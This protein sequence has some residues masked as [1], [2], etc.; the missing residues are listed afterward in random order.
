[1]KELVRNSFAAAQNALSDFLRDDSRLQTI[2]DIAG[3]IA[4][5]LQIGGKVLIFGNGGS[6]CDA[7]H[8]A[9]ELTGRFHE[10]RPALPAIAISDPAHITCVGN[11]YGFDQIFSRGVEAYGR[12]EDVVLGISTS[13]N[14][15]N[16]SNGLEAARK[17][18]CS[19]VA[20]LGRD[21]GKLAGTCHFQLI[22]PASDTARIQEI[23]T[24]IL[25]ILIECIEHKLFHKE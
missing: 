14:S 19:T 12:P 6:L 22:V 24:I 10:D 5:R 9:E 15:T 17:L 16:V 1:M 23:H 3:F 4:D 13:G 8:F 25:H 18:G 21:G 20:L 2:S 7:I 11:D